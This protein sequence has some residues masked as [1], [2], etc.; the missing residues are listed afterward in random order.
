MPMLITDPRYVFLPSQSDRET[1]FNEWCR[2][3]TRKSRIAKASSTGAPTASTHS[4]D[5][6]AESEGAAASDPSVAKQQARDAYDAL[7]R[8]EATSTRMTWEEFRRK[9]KKDRRFFGFGRD[10]REREKTFRVWLKDL[11]ERASTHSSL[12]I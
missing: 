2:D 12:M 4:Q 11:G 6:L 8:T 10:D 1:A 7:L 3:A 5:L 9:W